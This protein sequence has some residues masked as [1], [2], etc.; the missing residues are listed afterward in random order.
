MSLAETV[1]HYLTEYQVQFEPIPHPKTASSRETAHATHVRE[2]HIAK[3]VIVKD[4][5]GFAMVVIPGSNWI[6]LEALNRELDREFELAA[7]S[8]TVA[9]FPDCRPGAIPPLGP[10]YDLETYVD[11]QLM[12]LANVF[13]EGG[14][15]THLVQVNG[16]DFHDLLKGARHG[17]FSH[18][19]S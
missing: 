17:H 12:S 3:A 6:K 1:R 19:E 8:E 14:D 4:N 11:E 9:M 5:K 13:F 18:N 7:E 15:H 10:A 2:D 16:Q